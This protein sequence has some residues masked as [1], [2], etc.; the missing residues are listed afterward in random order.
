MPVTV[1]YSLT[2]NYG[3]E[4]PGGRPLPD[5]KKQALRERWEQPQRKGAPKEE[6]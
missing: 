6:R 5:E 4:P 3:T 1:G 2:E